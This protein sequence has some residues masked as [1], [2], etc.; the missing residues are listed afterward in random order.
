MSRHLPKSINSC[1]RLRYLKALVESQ[2]RTTLDL[3]ERTKSCNINADLSDLKIM[4]V[5]TKAKMVGRTA[6]GRKVYA[7]FVP[8]QEQLLDS[9]EFDGTSLKWK[10]YDPREFAA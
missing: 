9:M 1:D 2:P 8:H 3:I 5:P 6:G 7:R 10:G 4:G